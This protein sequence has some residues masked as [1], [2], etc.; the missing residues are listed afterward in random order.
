MGRDIK[1]TMAAPVT[2]GERIRAARMAKKISARALSIEMGLSTST[3]TQWENNV[4]IPLDENLE[5][6]AKVLGVSVAALR[7]TEP[8]S[9]PVL[10]G[11]FPTRLRTARLAAG[12]TQ[13]GLSRQCGLA[14]DA[15]SRIESGRP[16]K[17]TTIVAL[18]MALGIA[19]HDLTGD[20]APEPAPP[21]PP[22]EPV[23]PPSPEPQKP[24][25]PE[26]ARLLRAGALRR[27]AERYRYND[28]TEKAVNAQALADLTAAH[29]PR[30]YP[31]LSIP[32]SD[33]LP[34]RIGPA[35]AP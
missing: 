22:P 18:A 7:G 9:R 5:A 11:I 4:N 24:M 26:R 13:V 2:L 25:E 27:M 31:N 14:D 19:I 30:G 6:V 35:S 15:V 32:E 1:R 34:M 16:P 28:E 12:L 10:S 33:N 3:V 17:R 8:L 29:W 21:P 20:G 23:L